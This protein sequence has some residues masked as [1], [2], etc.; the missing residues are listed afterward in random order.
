M[1][2]LKRSCFAFVLSLFIGCSTPDVVSLKPVQDTVIVV[3][4][5]TVF[6][7][8]FD[9]RQCLVNKSFDYVGIREETGNNDGPEV[10]RLLKFVGFGKG[11]AW[12]AALMSV[13]YA[14][15]DI[16]APISAWSPDWANA[17]EIIWQQ[18][19]LPSKARML[20][21]PADHFTIHYASKGRVGHVG[22]VVK[23]THSL[24]TFE[25]NTN[26]GGSREGDGTYFRIRPYSQIYK[27]N[28][29]IHD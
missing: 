27:I 6:I 5:D 8:K 13:M 14:E 26:D 3:K 7:Q 2:Y 19:D 1:W 11:Y 21:R 20:V 24:S 12:C 4:T 9:P 22:M 29:L 16:K 25:G 18:G 17:G 28:R 10:E 15:C 23:A